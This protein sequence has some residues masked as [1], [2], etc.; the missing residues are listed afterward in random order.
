MPQIPN[1]VNSVKRMSQKFDNL[2]TDKIS[3]N[4]DINNVRSTTLGGYRQM[5]ANQLNSF[6][7]KS[8]KG[9]VFGTNDSD[10][11]VGA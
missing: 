10:P 11:A 3:Q 1:I 7:N 9:Y 4:L 8:G 6:S 2:V 5:G